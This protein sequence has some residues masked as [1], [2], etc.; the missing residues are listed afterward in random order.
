[1]APSMAAPLSGP[2]SGVGV[3]TYRV[4]ELD[5]ATEEN[6]LRAVLT[7]LT[8][9]R[10][11]EFDLVG[12][13]VRVRHDLESPA[14][15]EAAIRELGMRPS[16]VVGAEGASLDRSLSRRSVIVT[17]VAGLFAVGSEVAVILGADEQSVLVAVLAVI[18]IALGGRD[19]LRKGFQ[20]LRSRRM[21][22][23]LLMSVAVIGAIAIGQ[24][25]EAAVVIWLFGVAEL[26]EALSLERARNA[27]RSL[28]GLAPETASMRRD[29]GWVAVATGEVPLDA[30]ILVKPG[31]RI[32]LDGRVTSGASSVNQAPITGE[33]IPVSKAVGDP[34]FAGTINE[35]G[36]LE[37][38]V[39]AAKGE[40]T[41][42]RI[43]RSIQEAQA[44]KAPAQR[45][46]D[47][48]AAIYTPAVFAM[49]IIV[50]VVP[51]VT[52]HGSFHDW[53]YRALVL[54]VLACP[55]ALV[56]ST[57]VTVVSGL[58]GAARRGILIKGGVHLENARKIR[59]VAL[60]KTGTLTHGTPVLTDLVN[61]G[62]LTDD[63]VLR[64]TASI[65]ALSEHPVAHA[66][67]TAYHGPLD[68]AEEFE[69]ITGRGVRASIAGTVYTLGNHRLA[70]ETGMCGPELEAILEGLENEAKT[71]IVLMNAHP[72]AVLAV[73]DTLRP[74]SRQAVDDL[75]A[76]GVTTIMLTGDNQRTAT[77]IAAQAGI[78]DAR[79][80]LL[81]DD[82]LRII[83]ELVA[84]AGPV[85]MVGDGVNDAPALAKADLGI[86][87]GAAGTDTAIET[88]D[89][90]LMDDDPRKI[91]ETIRISTHT[92]HVLWQNITIALG[93]K[94]VFLGL[95]LTGTASL[96][97]AVLAD[98]G[99]SLVVIANGLR[100]L[101]R[102]A[103]GT[104]ADAQ[105]NSTARRPAAV[106][107]ADTSATVHP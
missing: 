3:V 42:D 13:R 54:L 91:A 77:A 6:D 8:G 76:L 15:I 16:V 29:G 37:I 48:F 78:D 59:T 97:I 72:I 27:I 62:E 105:H 61:L 63:E 12:R 10:S 99:A 52:G 80:D 70:E 57:P 66:I 84:T 28:V 49:A 68:D 33:S 45:F 32:A 41:L 38:T 81:P 11:L 1:M 18:A 107:D 65:E 87:M 74:N 24:W 17:V 51:V 58:G 100:L 43:A 101:R 82:K 40:G 93:V 50:A 95:T 69:A 88:A 35:R 31:E 47:R 21:T 53:F 34:V 46:V 2:S 55:C 104:R 39:T 30:V 89:I 4:E 83:T 85:G 25:P 73:A 19:T 9:V 22:M 75:K 71:A 64:I 20:A 60:D 90:A 5:C 92:A 98:M 14:P 86:A 44:D 26:I 102:P 96:W 94:A 7:P 79:G 23:S 67:V 103:H 106:A 56:I 36:T